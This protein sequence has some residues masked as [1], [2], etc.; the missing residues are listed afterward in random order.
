MT[1]YLGIDVGTS[2][3]R[4][5]LVGDD[6]SIIAT[7]SSSYETLRGAPGVVEQNPTDWT[8]ALAHALSSMPELASHPPTAIGL[9]GQTPTVV[10]VDDRGRPTRNALTW[11]DGRASAEALELGARFGDPAVLVGTELPWS[12]ANMPAK[13]LWLARHEP[14]LRAKTRT[15]LQ[16]KDFIG[17]ELTGSFLSDP[18]SSKGLCR[19]TDG[20][21]LA[22]VLV[23]CGWTA[24]VCPPTA[25]PWTLRGAV[26]VT[27]AERY[28]LREGTPVTVGAS[29]A[30]TEMISAGC[31]ARSSA[32]VF[33]GTS[34]IVGTAVDDDRVR[35]A[36]LFSVPITCAPMPLL[37]GP[38]QSG[39]AALSWVARLLG[40]EVDEVLSLA[41]VSGPSWP[42]FVP[43][44]A[45]ERAPL[46][47]LDVRALFLGVDEKH[48]RA[49]IAMSVVTS[50]FLAARHVLTLIEEATHRELSEVEVVG[51][52]V[53]NHDWE[54]VA[55][56]T[57]GLTLRFHDDSDMSARGAAMLA[58]AL[59][60]TSVVDASRR[61]S[62]ESRLVRP[63]PGE[64]QSAR[65]LLERYR[66][67]SD[68]G[69]Q[70]RHYES[71]A[72]H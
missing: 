43:Y 38:T 19:V 22:D 72:P 68:Q 57:L 29:D 50:I 34:S 15:I 11:Q 54:T 42:M 16:P 30:L 51:R 40:C 62:A 26:S 14:E 67:A 27:A 7:T 28:G 20:T 3:T 13:L 65:R 44:L 55:R 1:T 12:A 53:R 59:D 9:C 8:D 63:Q 36:G 56:Q 25:P 64:A 32:F 4:V 23:A 46:W 70:W 2:A 35:V 24:T 17:L 39:G 10:A 45:G 58:L 69:V 49:E 71:E 61:L 48:G 37:Y 31:F 6:G 33:S 47:D 41:A 52:G 21:P 60:G 18:W 66:H 5:V